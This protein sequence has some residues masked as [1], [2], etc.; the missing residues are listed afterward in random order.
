MQTTK[1]EKNRKKLLTNAGFG[2]III[3]LSHERQERKVQESK[4][5]YSKKHHSKTVQN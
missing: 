4:K 2:A 3:K 1:D 5:E